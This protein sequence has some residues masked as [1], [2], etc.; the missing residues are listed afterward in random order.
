MVVLPSVPIVKSIWWNERKAGKSLRGLFQG[1]LRTLTWRKPCQISNCNNLN[2]QHLPLEQE[3]QDITV[4][5]PSTTIRTLLEIIPL[6]RDSA[7]ATA[8]LVTIPLDHATVGTNGDISDLYLR[9]SRFEYR[10]GHRLIWL[11]IFFFCSSK[12]ISEE[13]IKLGHDHFHWHQFK[14]ILQNYA[15]IPPHTVWAADN[16]TN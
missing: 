13:K 14:F 7:V 6:Y 15:V 16:T 8:P 10:W 4:I 3:T 11:K 1:N 9:D 12:K 5:A 2:S